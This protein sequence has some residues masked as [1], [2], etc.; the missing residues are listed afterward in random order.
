[1]CKGTAPPAQ[2]FGLH[3]GE[4]R[5][6]SRGSGYIGVRGS[7]DGRYFGATYGSGVHPVTSLITD[8]ARRTDCLRCQPV[9]RRAA[10]VPWFARPLSSGTS[11]E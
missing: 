10:R 1:M 8:V 2:L 11:A 7:V 9:G 6:G 5:P 3:Q 4:R